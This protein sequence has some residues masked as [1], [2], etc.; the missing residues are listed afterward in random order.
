MNNHEN[1]KS[2]FIKYKKNLHDDIYLDENDNTI[3]IKGVENFIP[4]V[5]DKSIKAIEYCL[6]NFKF[7]YLLR[8][9]MSSFIIL[10]KLYNYC[11][12]NSIDCGGFIS[13]HYDSHF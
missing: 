11:I 4:G 10:N 8:T 1:I 12:N 13:Y 5:L 9:N 7:D 2:Y 6:H 3:Y